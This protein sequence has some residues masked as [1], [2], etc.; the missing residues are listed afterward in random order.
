MELEQKRPTWLN[1][2]NFSGKNGKDAVSEPDR[3]V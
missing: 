1:S 3:R 2:A